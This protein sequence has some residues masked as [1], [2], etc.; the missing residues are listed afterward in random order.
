M[1]SP[2]IIRRISDIQVSQL[3]IIRFFSNENKTAASDKRDAL[4][5]ANVRSAGG[6]TDRRDLR[7]QERSHAVP[8]HQLSC[9]SKG[10]QLGPRL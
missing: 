8:S 2:L 10:Q 9:Q 6:H 3:L 7:L 5:D 1:L 4:L